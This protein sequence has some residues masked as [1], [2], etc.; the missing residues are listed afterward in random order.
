M[1][2]ASKKKSTKSRGKTPG[3]IVRIEGTTKLGGRTRRFFAVVHA[4]VKEASGD[5]A[6][7]VQVSLRRVVDQPIKGA[8]ARQARE[9]AVA[10]VQSLLPQAVL[11]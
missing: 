2:V 3:P 4:P 9:L 8:T 6:C 1:I 11:P 10:F 7:R 5:H